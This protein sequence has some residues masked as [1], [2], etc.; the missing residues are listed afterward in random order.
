MALAG[1]SLYSTCV[2]RCRGAYFSLDAAPFTAVLI[3]GSLLT[4]PVS[5]KTLELGRIFRQI[6]CKWLPIETLAGAKPDH[7]LNPDSLD[8]IRSLT[9]D[10]CQHPECAETR[11]ELGI[12]GSRALL[13]WPLYYRDVKGR[14]PQRNLRAVVTP[15]AGFRMWCWPLKKQEGMGGAW[16]RAVSARGEGGYGVRAYGGPLPRFLPARQRSFPAPHGTFR[17]QND[18]SLNDDQP[19]RDGDAAPA[20]AA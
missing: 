17:P 18:A 13:D 14:G 16:R 20:P 10:H 5:K 1:G 8:E 12:L 19:T 3:S 11:F 6:F 2:L 15:R 7:P 9:A 4:P